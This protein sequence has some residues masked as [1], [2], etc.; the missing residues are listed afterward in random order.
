M[1]IIDFLLYY[2]FSIAQKFGCKVTHFLSFMQ[3]KLR[4]KQPNLH[5]Y[6]PFVHFFDIKQV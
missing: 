4:K 5:N 1:L 2:K 3:I 6:P